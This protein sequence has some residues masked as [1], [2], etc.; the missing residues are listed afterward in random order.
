MKLLITE[1][2]IDLFFC[3]IL[4]NI[5]FTNIKC[6]KYTNWSHNRYIKYLLYHY[7]IK[8]VKTLTLKNIYSTQYNDTIKHNV[9][10]I[11]PHT[12]TKHP[13]SYILNNIKF[14]YKFQDYSY[15]EL[16]HTEY[17]SAN[18]SV[19]KFYE[20]LCNDICKSCNI[21]KEDYFKYELYKH[22]F[23]TSSYNKFDKNTN[24]T[25]IME[26]QKLQ[27]HLVNAIP[28]T[29]I[30]GRAIPFS[31]LKKIDFKYVN[32][33]FNLGKIKINTYE[34]YDNGE[35]FIRSAKYPT[36]NYL[37]CN[38]DFITP[39]FYITGIKLLEPIEETIPLQIS[40]SNICTN[41]AKKNIIKSI[42]NIH[43][44]LPQILKE[45]GAMVTGSYLLQTIHNVDYKTD[46]DIFC[47]TKSIFYLQSCLSNL[48]MPNPMFIIRYLAFNTPY[49]LTKI[50]CVI[51]IMFNEK[52][53]Q[54]IAIDCNNISNY[55]DNYFDLSFCKVRTDG[56]NI[57]PNDLTDICN[58]VGTM[59]LNHI[60]FNPKNIHERF[61]KYSNRGYVINLTYNYNFL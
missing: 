6:I 20:E 52:L 58:K 55:I 4:S 53:I 36:R 59:E 35:R 61:V 45:C 3:N 25:I 32:I 43:K 50:K 16:Y 57:Y 33:I 11:I 8:L 5:T 22:Y 1:I 2:D 13:I 40:S 23:S 10:N 15:I 29:T 46:I 42:T 12:D 28:I 60:P 47:P 48:L 34:K 31:H 14:C 27:L 30:D 21:T 39:C 54:I 24:K 56:T 37:N 51:D 17:N 7:D 26:K 18:N 9:F 44:D 41:D 49:S 19:L 38:T